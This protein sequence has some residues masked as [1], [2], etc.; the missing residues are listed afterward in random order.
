MMMGDFRFKNVIRG[1]TIVN[2]QSAIQNFALY[3]PIKRLL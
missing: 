3:L 2:L 1:W